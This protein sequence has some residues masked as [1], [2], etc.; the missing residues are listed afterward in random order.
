MLGKLLSRKRPWLPL[1]VIFTMAAPVVAWTMLGRNSPGATEASRVSQVGQVDAR[2]DYVQPSYLTPQARM[3]LAATGDRLSRPG[4]ERL[5]ISG[6]LT[7]GERSS[8]PCQITFQLPLKLRVETSD[9]TIAFDGERTSTTKGGINAEDEKLLD[10][11]LLD[12]TERFLYGQVQGTPMR[13]LGYRFRMDDGTNPKY[14]GPYYDVYQVQDVVSLKGSGSRPK[15]YYFSSSTQLLEKVRYEE[16]DGGKEI[17]VQVGG[18]QKVSNQSVPGF[19]RRLE[20]GVQVFAL[21]LG[22]GTVGPRVD[23]SI[24]SW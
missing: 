23:D 17:E 4:K 1:T 15:R 24:F 8:I 6:T 5:V 12:T 20:N 13:F 19:I 16:S 21:S 10:S 7:T 14:E 2:R 3:I 11:T 22:S 18:W 9:G